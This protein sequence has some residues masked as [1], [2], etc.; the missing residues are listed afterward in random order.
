MAKICL[1]NIHSSFQ[2]TASKATVLK[3]EKL[4]KH[5]LRRWSR[6]KTKLG[7]DPWMHIIWAVDVWGVKELWRSYVKA[8]LK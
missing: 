8:L 6:S 1:D 4:A 2:K 5:I 7:L 3:G